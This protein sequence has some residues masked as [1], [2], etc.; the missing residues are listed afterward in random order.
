MTKALEQLEEGPKAEI[1]I[2]L[3]K[4]TQIISSRKMPGH[5]RIHGFWLR[6]FTSIYDRLALEMNRCLK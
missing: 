4:M 3:L 2:D 1:H 6:K 5:D